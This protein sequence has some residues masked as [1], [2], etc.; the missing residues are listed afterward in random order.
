MGV[1]YRHFAIPATCG[2][3]PSP[4]RVCNL[5]HKLV[6][7]RYLPEG[8]SELETPDNLTTV[9]GYLDE[10]AYVALMGSEF[11]QSWRLEWPSSGLLYAF[12]QQADEHACYTLQICHSPHFLTPLSELI[13][14]LQDPF[15]QEEEPATEGLLAKVK[16]LLSPR[17]QLLDLAIRCECGAALEA[18]SELFVGYTL[19]LARCPNCGKAFRPEERRGKLRSGWS[20]A[21][22]R[23]P[24]GLTH[25]FAVV[26]DCGK[27]SPNEN[28]PGSLEPK[29]AELI[30]DCI[31]TSLFEFPDL[32]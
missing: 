24:G 22:N 12:T 25:R 8:P 5:V 20:S 15:G 30:S 23:R 19:L 10:D 28:G 17:V 7:A 14:P 6:E 29:L 9:E 26:F 2:L 1:E 31:G 32:Y 11:R 21:V 13:E 4:A 18:T 3:I 16:S 27:S